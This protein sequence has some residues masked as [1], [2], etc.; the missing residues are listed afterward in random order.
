MRGN[1][2]GI[3]GQ[4]SGKIMKIKER[5]SKDESVDGLQKHKQVGG[6]AA[7]V[8]QDE[9]GYSRPRATVG[10]VSVACFPSSET[11]RSC[12]LTAFCYPVGN[13]F[14]SVKK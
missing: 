5:A 3:E 7:G 2:T 13:F 1:N 14:F 12:S 11:M 4:C 9:K 6:M 10:D 8:R